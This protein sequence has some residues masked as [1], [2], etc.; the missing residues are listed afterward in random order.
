MMSNRYKKI[1]LQ[2]PLLV[3]AFIGMFFFPSFKNCASAV[4]SAQS[5]NPDLQNFIEPY[6]HTVYE[7]NGVDHMNINIVDLEHSGL[8]TGDE[9][10]VFDGNYCVGATIINEN[11]IAENRLCVAASAHTDSSVPNGYIPGNAISLKLYR[12]G[13]VYLLYFITVNESKS[14]FAVGGSMFAFV[15]FSK[16]KRL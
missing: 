13:T 9:I 2:V 12:K 10:G 5:A 15:D 7:G 8:I 14:N 1:F 16:S 4:S 11:Q 3:F 6:F